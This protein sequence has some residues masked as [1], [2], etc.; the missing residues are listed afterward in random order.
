MSQKIDLIRGSF[1]DLIDVI[2]FIFNS[3][4]NSD[5]I[6]K[7]LQYCDKIIE[8]L[9]D[10][11]RR[12]VDGERIAI[13][14]QDLI[15]FQNKLLRNLFHENLSN[16]IKIDGFLRFTEILKAPIQNKKKKVGAQEKLSF[17]SSCVL[18]ESNSKKIIILFLKL[19]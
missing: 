7:L 14:E 1:Q 2:V 19:F 16:S 18:L 17:Y 6:T 9:Y 13:F 4:L 15:S 11:M 5:Q 3:A 8:V 10:G 12:L